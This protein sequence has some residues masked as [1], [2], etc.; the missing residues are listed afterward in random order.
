MNTCH[1]VHWSPLQDFRCSLQVFAYTSYFPSSPES[2]SP[3]LTEWRTGFLFVFCFFFQ[4]Y[5]S[6][7]HW[8]QVRS[9]PLASHSLMRNTVFV[10]AFLISLW[11]YLWMCLN[12][13][14]ITLQIS[15]STKPTKQKGNCSKPLQTLTCCFRALQFVFSQALNMWTLLTNLH[16]QVF[17]PT[18][19]RSWSKW[20]I[21]HPDFQKN[22][23]IFLCFPPWT[24]QSTNHHSAYC[25]TSILSNLAAR[26]SFPNSEFNIA[27][28]RI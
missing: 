28:L 4:M 1:G 5:M 14:L 7:S 9:K 25:S 6:V 17:L 20:W 27:T 10:W 13:F 24:L 26:L 18:L 11:E 3:G 12:G 16:T 8:G 2:Y 22:L 19:V 23:R 21:L 15:N